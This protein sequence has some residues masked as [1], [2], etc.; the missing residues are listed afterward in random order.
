MAKKAANKAK[1]KPKTRASSKAKEGDRRLG[2]QFWRLRSKHGRDKLFETPE[3]LW[4]AA[5]EYFNWCQNNP[6]QEQK[7]F[8]FQGV[9]TKTSLTKMRAMTMS[10]LCFYLNCNEAYFRNFKLQLPEGETGFNA[11]IRDI[12]Q[13]VYNQ[14]F[15]GAAAGLLDANIIARDLGLKDKS[16]TELSGS[17]S[18]DNAHSIK[19]IN[20]WYNEHRDDKKG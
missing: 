6:L 15:Q 17:I 12:E 11:V 4:E 14:K 8:A 18:T 19:N 5:C 2:N 9:I 7:A 20:D 1:A 3:L 10:Q 16:E 13:V